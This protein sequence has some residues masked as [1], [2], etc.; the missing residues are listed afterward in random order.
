MNFEHALF[1]F[2]VAFGAI[3]AT[4][5]VVTGIADGKRRLTK[6]MNS[7]QEPPALL[8]A[9]KLKATRQG[10]KR[11]LWGGAAFVLGALTTVASCLVPQCAGWG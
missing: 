9:K 5:H 11:M 1:Y 8:E 4:Y 6:W 3:Y 7:E 10:I 2:L